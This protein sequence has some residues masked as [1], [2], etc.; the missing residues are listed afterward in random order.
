M[1]KELW[2]QAMEER[3]D[4][5]LEAGVPF[6]DAYVRATNEAKGRMIDRLADAADYERKRRREEP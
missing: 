4:E 6:N 3:L 2:L 1:S 5:L